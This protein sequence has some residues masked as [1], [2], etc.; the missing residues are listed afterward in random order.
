MKLVSL[1]MY[2]GKEQSN[3]TIVSSIDNVVVPL[4]ERQAYCY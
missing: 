1:E 2:E 4:V 3:T